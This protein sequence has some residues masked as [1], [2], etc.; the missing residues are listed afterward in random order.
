MASL[1]EALCRLISSARERAFTDPQWV[2]DQLRDSHGND[3]RVCVL[4]VAAEEEIARLLMN[5]VPA[6]VLSARLT[7]KRRLEPNSAK[8]ATAVWEHALGRMHISSI[9]Q[10]RPP[11]PFDSN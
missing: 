7:S 1:P 4:V 3:S 8:W 5:G 11:P 6:H 10:L 9:P 2:E